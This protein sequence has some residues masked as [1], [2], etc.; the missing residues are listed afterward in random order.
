MKMLFCF[1]LHDSLYKSSTEFDRCAS[2]LA[3]HR[4]LRSLTPGSQDFA[5]LMTEPN[6]SPSTNKTSCH[7]LDTTCESAH[8]S[9]GVK[10][11][12]CVD[13]CLPKLARAPS[14]KYDHSCLQ[15]CSSSV[16]KQ[17]SGATQRNTFRIIQPTNSGNAT[18]GNKNQSRESVEQKQDNNN[19][20]DDDDDNEQSNEQSNK[21]S[22]ERTNNRTI[23][24]FERNRS[25]LRCASIDSQ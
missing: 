17:V 4:I 6:L 2:A 22:N 3:P 14:I 21:Q 13:E 8:Q 23:E 18:N 25:S 1:C 19:Y 24:P 16:D 11:G 7:S 12:R 10:H 5:D 9:T 20:D 15:R